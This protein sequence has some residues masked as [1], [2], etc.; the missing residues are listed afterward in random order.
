MVF[1]SVFPVTVGLLLTPWHL[2][3]YALVAAL[4][5]LVASVVLYVTA[6]KEG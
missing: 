1:Q 3:G 6:R 5:A 2:Q 4:V